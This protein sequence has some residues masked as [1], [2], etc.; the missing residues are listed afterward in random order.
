MHRILIINHY[1]GSPEHG[2]E[3]RPFYF[4]REWVRVGHEV[5]IVAASHSHLRQNNPA[6]NGVI[7]RETIEDVNYL[8]VQ[9]PAYQGNGA[10]RVLNMAAFVARL[11]TSCRGAIDNFRPDLVIASST[12]TWDNWPAAWYAR[13]HGARHVYELHD[14][15]PL[16][17][18]ELGGMSRFH[19]FIVALQLAEDFAC[20][21]ADRV[22]SMLP[23]VLPHLR[24]HGMPEGRLSYIPNGIVREEW[25]HKQPIPDSHQKA[26]SAFR[27]T[28]K[29]LVGYAGGH[30]LSNALDVLV[31]AGAN[32]LLEEEGVGIVC[33]GSGVE[34]NRLENKAR[35]LGSRMLFLPPVPRRTVPLLLSEFDIL[36]L[37]MAQSPLYR[38]G[39]SPNK[40]FEY[41]MAGVPI[42]HAV[43]AAN[44]PVL[45]SVCGVSVIPGDPQALCEGIRKLLSL[46]AEARIEM[47]R[48]GRAYVEKNFSVDKLAMEFLDSVWPGDSTRK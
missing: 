5:L 37:G 48:R 4:A 39:I 13:R 43:E 46:S 47:G 26:I 44:D 11:Y 9:T 27:Q 35:E 45:E 41:M 15:W 21:K 31:E 29:H 18:M 28:H 23:A 8:W 30:A 22:V 20:R 17:P 32:H 14:V 24:E 25:L 16:T 12:Y 19:P 7:T 1:A 34:K 3:Y 33:I 10:G 36:F 38:F 42:V 6:M 2:M 40:L